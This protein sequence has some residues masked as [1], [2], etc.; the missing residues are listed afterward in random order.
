MTLVFSDSTANKSGLIQ[1]CESQIFGDNSYGRISGDASLLATFTRYINEALNRVASLIMNS[2]GRWQWDDTNNTDYPIGQTNLGVTV[3]S[4]QQDYTFAVNFLKILRVEVMDNTGAWNKL[5]PIDQT[6]LYDSSLT[7]F[8]KTAGL[9]RYYDKMANSIFLYPKP[10][11]TSVTATAGLKVWFERPPSYFT[12]ADTVK[13]PGFN[14]LYH[15]LIALIASR[16][17]AFAKGLSNAKALADL[18][19]Q[20]EDSLSENYALRNKDEHIGLSSKYRRI[21]QFR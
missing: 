4:E 10:L 9:P 11:G 15:R 21:G 1:E 14:S 6:D 20:G 8:L 13:V 19:V 17:Y 12:V 16:D 3:G 5:T 18:V 2:E 7:D